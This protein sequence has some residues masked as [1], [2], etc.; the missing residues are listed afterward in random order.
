MSKVGR[1]LANGIFLTIYPLLFTLNSWDER[2][3]FLPNFFI[4]LYSYF[5]SKVY[6]TL[7]E[8]FR[9]SVTKNFLFSKTA[10]KR[11]KTKGDP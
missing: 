2:P 9:D 8:H 6:L 11:F 7:S 5:Y 3:A 10:G 1:E 4:I